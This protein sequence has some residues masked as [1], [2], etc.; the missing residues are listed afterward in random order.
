MSKVSRNIL[1]TILV[2]TSPRKPRFAEKLMC[3]FSGTWTTQ[4]S[5]A[6][7]SYSTKPPTLNWSHW[8]WRRL[9]ASKSSNFHSKIS[10]PTLTL[11]LNSHSSEL[12]IYIQM[13]NWWTQGLQTAWLMLLIASPSTASQTNWKSM[14]SKCLSL[15]FKSRSTQISFWTKRKS[16]KS[17]WSAH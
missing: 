7:S 14:L 9:R 2:L 11:M 5:N 6:S 16:T 4:R 3:S 15:L 17:C 1:T 12:K 8:L 10:A 13:I